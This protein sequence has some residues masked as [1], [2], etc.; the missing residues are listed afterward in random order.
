[1][2][3]IKFTNSPAKLPTTFS[4]ASEH[5]VTLSGITEPNTSG[6]TTWRLDGETQLGDFSGYTTLYRQ[7][8]NGIQLSDDGSVWV[9]P[10]PLP[11]PGPAGPTQLDRIEAQAM[12]TAMMTDTLLQEE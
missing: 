10:E 1:M 3:L 8:D 7:L 9:A 5:I 12:Y 6:F 11:E 2:I 4:R